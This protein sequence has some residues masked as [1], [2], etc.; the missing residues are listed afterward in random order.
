M[1]KLSR[2]F[3]MLSV[4]SIGIGMIAAQADSATAPTKAPEDAPGKGI[5]VQISSHTGQQPVL[6]G[7]VDQP[8]EQ[9]SPLISRQVIHGAQSTFVV[10]TM[11]KGAIVPLHH[12]PNEQITW[13]TKGQA[14]VY[15][16]GKK[17]VM[18]AGDLMVVPANIPHEF[19]IT[20]DTIDVDIFAPQRQ[21]WIDGTADYLK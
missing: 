18:N 12:H 6:Y 5:Q 20:E 9:V 8:V 16:G 7:L 15:S 2:S 13:I 11:K 3:A 1:R 17:Y 19:V 14:I 10:W 4:W 21:D